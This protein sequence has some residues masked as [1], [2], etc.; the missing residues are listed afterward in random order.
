MQ[1]V[2]AGSTAIVD[3]SVREVTSPPTIERGTRTEL[4][5]RKR[6]SRVTRKAVFESPWSRK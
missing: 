5:A 2:Q 6:A 3:S 1:T 4:V